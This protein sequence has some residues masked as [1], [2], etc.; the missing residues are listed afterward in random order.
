MS[1]DFITK[2]NKI[3]NPEIEVKPIFYD[4]GGDY[5][6]VEK[7][8]K[9]QKY[10]DNKKVLSILKIKFLQEAPIGYALM[11]KKKIFWV[12]WEQFF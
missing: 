2:L 8:L 12:F 9:N 4:Q 7:F 1:S 3:K 11:D 6:A 10:L 5:F